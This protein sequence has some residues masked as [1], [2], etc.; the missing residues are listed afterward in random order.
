MQDQL[1]SA[2]G[3]IN[4]IE[5]T[6][7]P[8]ANTAPIDV[9]GHASTALAQQLVL[10]YLGRGHDSSSLHE[11]VI[12]TLE[13]A[14]PQCQELEDLR[15]C[16]ARAATALRDGDVP[17]F[18]HAMTDNTAAQARLHPDLVSAGAR[19]VIDVAR[20][21]GA[22][23]W[24]VNGAG[25]DGGSITLLAGPSTSARRAMLEALARVNPLFREIPVRPSASGVRRWESVIP[26][27]A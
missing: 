13:H 9:P 3:G 27:E 18:G 8:F 21:H 11:R 6:S 15:G 12:Q 7:Y 19:V 10:I 4:D 24:K 2:L 16:A 26:H 1:A 5:I 17:G 25:G 20:A 22:L 23:G 14:G